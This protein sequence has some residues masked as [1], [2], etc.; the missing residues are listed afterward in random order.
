MIL[1]IFKYTLKVILTQIQEI[2]RMPPPL[3]TEKYILT[4]EL[5]LHSLM[6]QSHTYVLDR[7][8]A[9]D[10]KYHIVTVRGFTIDGYAE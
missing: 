3:Q 8:N 7:R 5:T 1:L 9:A 2:L 10:N 4:S 6:Q